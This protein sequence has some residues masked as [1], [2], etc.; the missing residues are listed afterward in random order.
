[1]D[2]IS[3]NITKPLLYRYELSA[4]QRQELGERF[5][6]GEFG[7][8]SFVGYLPRKITPTPKDY[9]SFVK[10]DR[11]HKGP[12]MADANAAMEKWFASGVKYRRDP[13]LGDSL[14]P[15]V[16]QH[17]M[18]AALKGLLD[19]AFGKILEGRAMKDWPD[20]SIA[21]P[22]AYEELCIALFGKIP[23]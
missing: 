8:L 17:A 16:V 11:P 5:R 22:H 7:R 18:P 4:E 21:T 2:R 10:W 15:C 9:L 6:K 19:T 23:I 12:I 20:W 13:I 1:M 14:P 3:T